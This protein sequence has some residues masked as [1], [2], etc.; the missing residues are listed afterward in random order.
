M[1]VVLACI[2]TKCDVDV[3]L[4]CF[5][6]WTWFVITMWTPIYVRYSWTI[7]ELW[8]NLWLVVL[9]HVNHVWSW[10]VC[11]FVWDA[12]WFYQ[13]T[14]F[15]WAQV[16]RFDRFGDCYCTCALINWTVL[17]QLAPKQ[18]STLNWSYGYLKQRF[19]FIKSVWQLIAIYRCVKIW[20]LNLECASGHILYAS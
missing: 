17:L 11:W 15:I 7:S 2:W 16:W 13:T 20:I 5:A 9:N 3:K 19:C 4:L 14:R 1:T 12:L 18:G 10:F 6:I 8:C